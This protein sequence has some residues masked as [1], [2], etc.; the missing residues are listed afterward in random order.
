MS[1]N[2][3]QVASSKQSLSTAYDSLL[4][5]AYLFLFSYLVNFSG[6]VAAQIQPYYL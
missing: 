5:T 2:E 4:A 3:E 6:E 1:R